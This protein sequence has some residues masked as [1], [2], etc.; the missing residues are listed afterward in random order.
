M[1]GP[2]SSTVPDGR[3]E[4]SKKVSYWSPEL[5]EQQNCPAGTGLEAPKM[6]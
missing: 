3:D 1:K 6:C 4:H 2:V 5:L